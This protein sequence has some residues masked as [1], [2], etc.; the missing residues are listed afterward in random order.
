MIGMAIVLTQVCVSVSVPVCSH[1]R[2]PTITRVLI[3]FVN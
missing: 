1:L 3:A 2:Q